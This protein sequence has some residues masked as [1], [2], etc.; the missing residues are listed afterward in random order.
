M[1]IRY[2]S[3][4]AIAVAL[5]LQSAGLSQIPN[6]GFEN[7]TGDAPDGWATS[8]VPAVVTPVTQSSNAHTGTSAVRGVVASL[9]PIII[10]PFIQSGPLGQGFPYTGRPASFTGHYQF[11]PIGGDR[12]GINVGLF[13]GGIN[14]T[15]IALAAEARPTTVTSYTQ[16]SVPFVYQNPGLPDTC[17]VQ[18]Q[19]VGPNG[20]DYHVGSSFLLDDIAF[21]GTADVAQGT[22]TM[23]GTTSLEQNYPNPFNPQTTISFSLSHQ[24]FTTL[25]IS[26]TLGQE[27]ATLL[28]GNLA[29]GTHSVQ[30]NAGNAA[31][32]VYYYTLQAGE[33]TQTKKL[34][35]LR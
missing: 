19:I 7:W 34:L 12:F 11:S 26:N 17:I 18:I 22:G 33:F 4:V 14:G 25:K 6:A 29:A 31:G 3:T 2:R 35:L 1:S 8:N 23:P 15:L 24:T 21:S 20:G 16:F 9:P 13:A 27:I 30:W 10:Q 28:S 32:G 5:L